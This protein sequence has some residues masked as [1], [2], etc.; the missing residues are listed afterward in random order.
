MY[1]FC[2][3]TFEAAENGGVSALSDNAIKTFKK[4]FE[5]TVMSDKLTSYIADIAY[6][7]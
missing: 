7:W 1:G 3:P 6:S 4:L 2:V 5:D